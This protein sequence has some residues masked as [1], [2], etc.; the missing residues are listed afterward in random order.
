ME[1][2]VPLSSYTISIA[3]DDPTRATTT[4]RV[5]VT[6]N[7]ARVTELLVRA[8]E[9]GGLTAGQLPAVDLDQLL[10]A[11]S[12]ATQVPAVHTAAEPTLSDLT[13]EPTTAQRPPTTNTEP[14]AATGAAVASTDPAT[15]APAPAEPVSAPSV[16]EPATVTEALNEVPTPAA[17]AINNRGARQKPPVRKSTATDTTTKRTSAKKT[18]AAPKATAQKDSPVRAA[19]KNARESDAAQKST[20]TKVTKRARP[21]AKTAATGRSAA[22]APVAA[23]GR[24]KK[25]AAAGQSAKPE[26]TSSGGRSY[27]R[28]PADL[29]TVLGQAGTASAVADHYGVPAH[30]AQS[31]IRTL[32]RKNAGS[33]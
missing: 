9:G 29:A 12:P 28:A 15:K 6:D 26:P 8:G 5:E 27:R 23:T 18:T 22:P 3:P 14:S 1:V 31:W 32:R 2:Y 10:R 16:A 24:A 33:R 11:V 25:A 20:P 30:T 4:L 17:G 19:K 7:T 21:V 13:V